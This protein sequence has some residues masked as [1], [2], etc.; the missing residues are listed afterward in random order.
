MHQEYISGIVALCDLNFKVFH[1]FWKILGYYLFKCYLSSFSLLLGHQLDIS[2]I[3]SLYSL[4]L[5]PLLLDFLCC[6]FILDSFFL[7]YIYF[8][9]LTFFSRKRDRAP[10]G[11]NQRER[12][13]WNLKQTPG[14][15]LSAQTPT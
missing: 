7:L 5:L 8:L 1:Q 13:T 2:K 4:Y 9:F 12:E 14:S 3:F 15:E 11:E 6:L 10:E